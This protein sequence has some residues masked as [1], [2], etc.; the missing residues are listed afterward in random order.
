M[1]IIIELPETM[2]LRGE[3]KS[4][5]EI[6]LTKWANPQGFVEYLIAY[7]WDVRMQRCT[8]GSKDT[9]EFREK[10]K[11][12]LASMVAGELPHKG[13]GGLSVS[14]DDKIATRFLTLMDIKGKIAILPE[15]WM[16]FARV[17]VLNSVDVDTKAVLQK[18]LEQLTALA[19]EYIDAVKESARETP[20]WAKIK[21]ELEQ[22]KAV[23]PA[24]PILQIKIGG[25]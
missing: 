20:E 2:T 14:L 24:K 12:M 15:R 10:E 21:A 22:P 18:D 5:I 8:A 4:Q 23:K 6:D 19:A 1:S 13:G 9:G 25:K 11:K 16:S 3:N 17:T 7:G